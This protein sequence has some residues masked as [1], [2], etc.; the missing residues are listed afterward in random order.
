MI[1]EKVLGA[2]AS[3]SSL[4]PAE[5]AQWYRRLAREWGISTFEIPLLA[6][7]PLPPEL[8]EVFGELPASLVVTLVAQWA[9][10]GQKNRAYGLSSV[11]EPA[12]QA[13]LLD[14]GSV[15]LYCLRLS[16][17]G[18]RI[19]NLVVH[20][21]QKTGAAIPHA[22]AFYRSLR[23][24]RER[25]GAVLPE[26]T[27]L[28]E[29]TDSRPQEHPIPFPAAKKASLPLPGLLETVVTVNGEDGSGHAIGLMANWGRLLVNGDL[30]LD[31]I[32]KM[33][34]S[35]APLAGV[36]FSGAGATPNGFKDSHNSHL[37]GESGFTAED[38]MVCASVLKCSSRPI[39]AGTKCSRARG[40]GETTVEEVLV[41]QAKL[42]K[43]I[44]E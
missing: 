40:A 11:H 36:I 9:V 42:L 18:I 21:G 31:S 7:Q 35:E 22:I 1:T 12:R 2:Y 33:L 20:T 39:F 38:A 37:D 16:D 17:Q 26:T 10:A 43:A 3:I 28:V 29:V 4:P 13:A 14:A 44:K 27:L 19:R 15:L 34:S 24:L 30:P 5:Q 41:A 6:G 25:V 32:Q 23:E 8:L